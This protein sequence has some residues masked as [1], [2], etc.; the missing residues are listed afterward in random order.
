MNWHYYL[1]VF[2][3]GWSISQIIG[4]SLCFKFFSLPIS[5]LFC[6]RLTTYKTINHDYRVLRLISECFSCRFPLGFPM[7]SHHRRNYFR[8]QY[9]TVMEFLDLPPE[10]LPEIFSHI[11]TPGHIAS[12]CLVNKTFR[13]FAVCELYKQVIIYSWDKEETTKA[14]VVIASLSSIL[15]R[16]AVFKSLLQYAFPLSISSSPRISY[17]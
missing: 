1:R 4:I 15:S 8:G 9:L 12:L 14:C 6:S 13:T 5:L 17:W 10:I 3:L 7:R 2:G 11:E 16:L